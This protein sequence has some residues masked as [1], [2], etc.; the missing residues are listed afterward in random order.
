MVRY[1]F[2][3]LFTVVLLIPAYGQ[4]INS[5]ITVNSDKVD[6]SL[7]PVFESLSTN[8]T[9]FINNRKWSEA[10]FSPNEK[11]QVNIA[12]IINEAESN[13]RFRGEIQV[14]SSRPVFNSA[15]TSPTF[16]FR[17]TDFTFNYSQFQPLEYNPSS[18]ESNLIAV[19]AFYVYMLLG[20]DFD[21]FSLLGGTSYFSQALTIANQAQSLNEAGWQ[22]YSGSRNRYQLASDFT[23]ESSGRF[24]EYLYKYHRHGLDEMALSVEKGRKPI[25]EG[26]P[27]VK[28]LLASR[29]NS[30]LV[31]LFAETKLDELVNLYAKAPRDERQ[32]VLSMLTSVYPTYSSKFDL[33]KTR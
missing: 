23:D 29:P 10:Q 27:T 19:V 8:L 33:L 25:T 32:N 17:D 20:V 6:G 7:R 28:S 9:E 5:R 14:Q 12:I 31:V 30:S 1:L 11:I 2:C 4:E 26:L 16:N 13:E 24:R 22:P 18:V 21:S 3:S 15:Y